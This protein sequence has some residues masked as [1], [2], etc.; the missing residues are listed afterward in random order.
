MHYALED[1]T[2]AAFKNVFF[3]SDD[4]K[5]LV[6][7]YCSAHDS[8]AQSLKEQ[9]REEQL[10]DLTTL[11]KNLNCVYLEHHNKLGLGHALLSVRHCI[12]KE[13]FGIALPH[14]IIVQKVS[15]FEQ[16][17]RL[18]R[19]EKCS[20]VAIQEVPFEAAPSYGMISVKKQLSPQLF[21]VGSIIDK[22]SSTKAPSN[23]A[24]V[25]RY[26]LSSK[27]LVA[28]EDTVHYSVKDSI[29]LHDGINTM[30][31]QG[32]KVI[33]VK[34][35]GLRYDTSTPVGWMKAV[36]GLGLQNKYYA[37]HL[38]KFLQEIETSDSYMYNPYKN[39]QHTL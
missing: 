11:L 39:I 22:P 19:Q 31:Q 26:I 5:K 12:Q 37:P 4:A 13:Y 17:T 15:I 28:L 1:C 7:D 21:Q 2:Q 27:L 9:N 14:D 34:I 29:S 36:I 25:G 18:A 32:E 23:F 38:K 35:Q 24:V 8:L 10:S 33:A 16:L 30:I 20:V 6:N 3:I